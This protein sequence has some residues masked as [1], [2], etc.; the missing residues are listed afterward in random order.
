MKKIIYSILLSTLF[1]SCTDYLT[2][3]SPSKFS[4]VYVFANEKDIQFAVNGIYSPMVSPPLWVGQISQ[5]FYFNTD[6]EL[7]S[8]VSSSGSNLNEGSFIP[9]T[10]AIAAYDNIWKALYDG[11]NRA[12][13]VI[14]GIEQCTLYKNADK[15]VPTNVSHYL[16]EAKVLRAMYYLELVRNWGDVPFRTA[17]AGDKDALLIGATDRDIILS[18][19]IDDLISAEPYMKH[20]S[21]SPR[22]GAEAASREFCQGMIARMALQ[23]G[24]Y[25]LRPD[26][27]NPN[28]TGTMQRNPDW[29][30]YYK[31]A[32]EYSGKVITEGKHKLN[33]SFSQVWEDECNWIVPSDDDNIF[34]VPANLGG[35]GQYGYYCGTP[36][37]G[38]TKDGIV[39]SNSPHGYGSG[40]LNLSLIYMLTFD[41]KDLRRDITCLRYG[42]NDSGTDFIKQNISVNIFV[43]CGKWNRLF[44]KSPL[45]KTSNSGTGINF[46]YMRYTD[47]LL[48][49]AEAANENHNAPTD[50]AKTAL[51]E[52]RKRAFDSADH[53]DKVEAYVNGLSGKDAFFKAIV[54][55]RAWEFGGEKHRRYDLARWNLYSQTIYNMYHDWITIGKVARTKQYE[56]TSTPFED[57]TTDPRF[58][59]YPALQYYKMVPAVNP[60]A[61]EV[62]L[63][64]EWYVDGNGKSSYDSALDSYRTTPAGYTAANMCNQYLASTGSYPNRVWTPSTT[65][66]YAFY[67]Y[68]NPGNAASLNP[69]VTP[70]RCLAPFPPSAL[71]SHQGLLKNY[72][73]Y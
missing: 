44:M 46:P 18:E 14:E 43:K 63:T 2:V 22:G 23:R 40:S 32:E 8:T 34:D 39:S 10:T 17:S 68:I 28:I 35:T 12:N 31:I 47:V 56:E 36:V 33:R 38:T 3:E 5:F 20:A 61:S 19:L 58:D 41:R 25:S 30:D 26:L 67:G 24:G 15:T 64:I 7:F 13:D 6:V 57:P 55:E 11:I 45:G 37:S 21:E 54:D 16:G 73:G 49:Y 53:G 59:D 4:Q 69:D 70:V 65:V 62:D 71:S 27:N 52:V 51:K 9:H 42:Y 29:A 1:V 72:Y 50:E 66:Q 48:M 60:V